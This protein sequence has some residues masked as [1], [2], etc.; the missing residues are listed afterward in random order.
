MMATLD[1]FGDTIKRRAMQDRKTP[2]TS[3]IQSVDPEN[4]TLTVVDASRAAD[5]RYSFV[6][7]NSWSRSMPSSGL[8]VSVVYSA[9]NKRLEVVG[10]QTNKSA[11]L[12]AGYKSKKNLY[13]PLRE[14]EHDVS[15][16][17]R[18]S[19]FWG[20][21]PIKTDRAGLVS[22]KHDGLKLE[23]GVR[24][25]TMIWRGVRNRPDVIGHE[26]RIGAVKRPLSAAK[27]AYALKIGS[28]PDLDSFIYSTEYLLAL[29]DMSTDAPLIDIRSGDVFDDALVPGY[30]MSMPLLG[31][32]NLPLRHRAKYFVTIEP[33]S[34][35]V[36]K[37]STDFEIDT[38]GNVNLTLSKL[39]VIGLAVKVPLGRIL[40][41][42]GLDM[43]LDAKLGLTLKTM[44]KMTFDALAG[45]DFTTKGAMSFDAVAGYKVHSTAN[46][47]IESDLTSE[48]SG[49]VGASIYGAMGKTGRP[50]ANLPNDP[51]TEI[52]LF[53]DAT[54]TN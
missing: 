23:Y 1:R 46:V 36:P 13:R 41:S 54:V 19:S 21:Q 4:E 34:I 30:P 31:T 26:L 12:I 8:R 53:M 25:P 9:E 40:V 14:G 49:K 15:S 38:L 32:N 16:S 5:I 39:S 10:Y 35:A 52:P 17:G 24:A 29:N 33:G 44:G 3:V 45:M 47:S 22:S 2:Y 48:I 6:S 42:C 27:E 51:V 28:L 50:I 43:T 20:S 11:D 18:T 37:Q 7:G